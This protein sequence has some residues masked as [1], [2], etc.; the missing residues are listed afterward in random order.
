LLDHAANA[1]T[2][3]YGISLQRAF[4]GFGG[5]MAGATTTPDP[6]LSFL[7]LL[8]YAVVFFLLSIWLTKRR[9]MV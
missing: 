3:T 6:I 1:V 8:V 5:R 7:V 4:G 2:A 9:E